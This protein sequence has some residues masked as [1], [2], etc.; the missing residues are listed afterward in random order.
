[1]RLL[2]NDQAKKILKKKDFQVP[3]L[4]LSLILINQ[5]GLFRIANLYWWSLYILSSIAFIVFVANILNSG[6][7][8]LIT[9]F[10]FEA[11]ALLIF[12]FVGIFSMVYNEGSIIDSIYVITLRALPIIFMVFCLS[13]LS[14]TQ[15]T[16]NHKFKN[17]LFQFINWLF[18]LNLI[19]GCF[20]LF[21]LGK[22]VDA[23]GS[24]PNNA[25]SFGFLNMFLGLLLW[26]CNK[27][28]KVHRMLFIFSFVLL[29]YADYKLGIVAF[30]ISLM[31]GNFFVRSFLSGKFVKNLIIIIA[32]AVLST[33]IFYFLIPYL[34]SHYGVFIRIF[35]HS[36]SLFKTSSVFPPSLELI[37]GYT[38]IFNEVFDSITNW[39][40]GMGPGNY[41]SNVAIAKSKPLAFKYIIRFREILDNKGIVRGTLLNRSNAT[42][43]LIAE[44]GLMGFLLY[45]A[46]FLRL[47]LHPIRTRLHMLSKINTNDYLLMFVLVFFIIVELPLFSVIES[48]LYL[49][50]FILFST[51]LKI[52]LDQNDSPSE[53]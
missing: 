40:I 9:K 29:I 46:V 45:T 3:F 24:I 53:S 19:V 39:I 27:F 16:K 41:G 23:L 33:T 37:K 50:V 18:Y 49:S 2:I 42:V 52:R 28:K 15:L 44:F 11:K 51:V 21:V 48:G 32:T 34:P 7:R 25:H 12:F 36:D 6:Q 30:F 38:Q 14:T 10:G 13:W 22:K 47:L 26:Q 31:A 35:S 43:S 5:I 1:M 17:C 20:Q 4:F 8:T